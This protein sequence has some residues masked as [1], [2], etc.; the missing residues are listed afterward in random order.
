MASF[1]ASCFSSRDQLSLVIDALQMTELLLVK[2]PDTYQFYFRREGVLYEIERMAGEALVLKKKEKE[3]KAS[4]STSTPV[5]SS[6]ST[7]VPGT[8]TPA[9]DGGDSPDLGTRLAPLPAILSAP[10]KPLSPADAILQDS[11]TLRARHLVKMLT[12]SSSDG[13]AKADSSLQKIRA[14]VQTLD[15]AAGLDLEAGQS[16]AEQA[17]RDISALF[18]SSNAMSSF[19]MQESGLIEGLLR[20]ATGGADSQCMF[21]PI[22][23]PRR[24]DRDCR[25]YSIK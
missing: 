24:A 18:A 7:P 4:S 13:S 1:L 22:C 17:L 10:A 21:P 20:F 6:A 15:N 8:A 23:Q 19:E 3:K 25:S 2:V 12:D 14:L 5:E 16:A 9:D 11:V